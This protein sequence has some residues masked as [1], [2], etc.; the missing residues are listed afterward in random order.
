[1][2]KEVK[3]VTI[4]ASPYG[5]FA[6]L[7]VKAGDQPPTFLADALAALPQALRDMEEENFNHEDDEEYAHIWEQ[8]WP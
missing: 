5:V 1:M 4:N 8:I 3:A 2:P 7:A 6:Q